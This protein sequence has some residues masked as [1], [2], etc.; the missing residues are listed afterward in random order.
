MTSETLENTIFVQFYFALCN[1]ILTI[2]FGPSFAAILMITQ[3]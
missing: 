2:R 3:K 1:L